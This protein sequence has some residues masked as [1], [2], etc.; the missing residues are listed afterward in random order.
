MVKEHDC[1]KNI[2]P[3]RIGETYQ[4][5]I[6][7]NKFIKTIGFP[8]WLRIIGYGFFLG[9]LF[10][11]TFGWLMNNHVL[12]LPYSLLGFFGFFIFLLGSS[13][14]AHDLQKDIYFYKKVGD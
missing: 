10:L 4:C 11:L 7:G 3:H 2:Y 5:D 14:V 8:T 12:S 6:C 1:I 9:G 13:V